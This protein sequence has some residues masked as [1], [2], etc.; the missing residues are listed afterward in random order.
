M[1]RERSGDVRT[2]LQPWQLDLQ[3]QQQRPALAQLPSG[4][5][6]AARGCAVLDGGMGRQAQP[7]Q[8]HKLGAHFRS[9]CEPYGAVGRGGGGSL[10]GGCGV[11]VS[12]GG[13]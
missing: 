1:L 12:R 8:P 4:A 5:L 2:E 6:R 10:A 9:C 13:L 7:A 11:S 3:L